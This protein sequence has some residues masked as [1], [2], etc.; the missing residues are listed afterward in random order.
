MSSLNNGLAEHDFAV[1]ALQAKRWGVSVRH[2]SKGQPIEVLVY[3]RSEG[4][5]LTVEIEPRRALQLAEKLLAAGIT[6][7]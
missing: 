2:A 1:H 5:W 7:L 4:K 6:E 3:C